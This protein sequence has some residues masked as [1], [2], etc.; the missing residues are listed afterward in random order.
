MALRD[1]PYL[2]LYVQDF[3][4]D[5]KLKE[6]SAESIGVYI[7]LMCL[8]HKMEEY[9]TVLLKQK[10]KQTGKQV[11]D[12]AKQLARQMHFDEATIERALIELLDEKVI[13]IEDDVL[14]QKRMVRDGKL[15]D[16]R[17]FAGKKGG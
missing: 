16:T 13:S 1:Q 17:A 6:C 12:F 2:P 9:G 4:T 7:M 14:F 5:E 8:M 10:Y 11:P 15:S 3:M